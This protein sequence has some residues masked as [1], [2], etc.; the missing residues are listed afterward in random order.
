M[1]W[2]PCKKQQPKV[3]GSYFVTFNWG[4]H[5][6]LTDKMDYYLSG[7]K[8]FWDKFNYRDMTY[9]VVAWMPA[10]PYMD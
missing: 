3:S 4:E 8:W 2:I 1:E 6:R 9:A 7:N 5:V 10:E